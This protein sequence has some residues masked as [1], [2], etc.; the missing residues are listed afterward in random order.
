P[1]P[2]APRGV[3]AAQKAPPIPPQNKI[4]AQTTNTPLPARTAAA[5]VEPG[6]ALA[7]FADLPRWAEQFT[8][9]SASL[10][11]GER[12]AWKR[13]EAMLELI[14]TDPGKA[15]ALAVPYGWRQ[16]LPPKVTR[17]FEEQVDGR[18]DFNVAVGTDFEQGISTVLRSVRLGTNHYK[19]FVYGRRLAQTCQSG[20]PLHGI[21]LEGKLALYAEPLRVLAREEAAA[22]A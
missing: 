14:Q 1:S 11:E 16:T 20:I 22:L 10:V 21:A 4:A 3:V 8:N 2:G 18:G 5:A 19:A 6:K 7:A 12:L 15:C 13:R 9:A 17:F